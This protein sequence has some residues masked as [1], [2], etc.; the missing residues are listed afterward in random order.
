MFYVEISEDSPV[1]SIM[2]S[3]CIVKLFMAAEEGRK[4]AE[5]YG[6]T[7]IKDKEDGLHIN[8]LLDAPANPENLKAFFERFD[9]KYFNE[10][11]RENILEEFIN[12]PNYQIDYLIH[13]IQDYIYFYDLKENELLEEAMP[14]YISLLNQVES[15]GFND[16][17]ADIEANGT[18]LKSYKILRTLN[19]L[20]THLDTL[21]KPLLAILNKYLEK[22]ISNEEL[23]SKLKN[24]LITAYKEPHPDFNFFPALRDELSTYTLFSGDKLYD[25]YSSVGH[26]LQTLDSEY[27]L[28][29]LQ[30]NR[31]TDTI[32]HSDSL[33]NLS[34]QSNEHKKYIQHKF[35]MSVEEPKSPLSLAKEL[36]FINTTPTTPIRPP[37]ETGSSKI[38]R[39]SPQINSFSNSK[40]LQTIRKKLFQSCFSQN[41]IEKI[42]FQIKQLEKEIKGGSFFYEARKLQ[43][44]QGLEQLI[45]S[46]YEVNSNIVDV[47]KKVKEDFPEIQ[48][49]FFSQ[50]TK[51]LLDEL[52]GLEE[53]PSCC[54]SL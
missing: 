51:I 38:T 52:L 7:P 26:F 9:D 4:F 35:N 31:K 36:N 2:V 45:K 1:K 47:I 14:N 44:K 6:F 20:R 40:G 24:Y 30:K 39:Y 21:L 53:E 15:F 28:P 33:F 17:P 3:G 46:S 11:L 25:L 48:A 27:E 22:K 49:G 5:Q 23:I 13:L 50:R 37:K 43:K 16:W 54:C 42:N 29:V 12:F 18:T 34:K 41:Q 10:D 19:I 8:I 32:K